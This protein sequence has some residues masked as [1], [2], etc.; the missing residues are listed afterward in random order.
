MGRR[1]RHARVRRGAG[2]CLPRRAA[3]IQEIGRGAGQ[4]RPPG[5]GLH[6]AIVDGLQARMRA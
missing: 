3:A 6:P 5:L 1:T 4:A 2:A